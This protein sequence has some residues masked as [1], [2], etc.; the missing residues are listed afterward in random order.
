MT[1]AK[2]ALII[3]ASRGLGLGLVQRICL[4]LGAS[5]TFTPRPGGGSVLRIDFM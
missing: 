2:T 3:G 5:L 4:H 1:S